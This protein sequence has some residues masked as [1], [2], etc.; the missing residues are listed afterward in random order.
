MANPADLHVQTVWD[1]EV[2]NCR[3]TPGPKHM[4]YPGVV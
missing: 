3:Y 2:G 1:G 4:A